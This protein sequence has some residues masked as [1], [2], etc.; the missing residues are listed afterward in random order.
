MN[1]SNVRQLLVHTNRGDD[2]AAAGLYKVFAPRMLAFARAFLREQASAEDSVQQ[3]FVRILTLKPAELERV[4]DVGAWLI[5]MTRTTCL[6]TVRTRARSTLR[7]KMR[8][9]HTKRVAM[10][11]CEANDPH[12]A[13]LEAINSLPDDHRELLLLKHVGGLTF[14]QVALSLGQNRNTLASRYRAAMDHVRE[15][16]ENVE[17]ER[18][19]VER[20]GVA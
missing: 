5:W 19:I 2:L 15:R 13:L 7:E 17:A 9:G 10:D 20:R 4:E 16:L 14:D 6:N 11:T 8:M 1:D 3:V 12:S 18:V